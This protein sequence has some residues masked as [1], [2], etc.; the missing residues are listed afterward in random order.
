MEDLHKTIKAVWTFV[1]LL[2]YG[3]A[4]LLIYLFYRWAFP[5]GAYV[6]VLCLWS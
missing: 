5:F 3:A 1:P 6:W 2:F 4:F